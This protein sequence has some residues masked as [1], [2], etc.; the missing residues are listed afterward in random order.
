MSRNEGA[1]ASESVMVHYLAKGYDLVFKQSAFLTVLMFSCSPAAALVESFGKRHRTVCALSFLAILSGVFSALAGSYFQIVPISQSVD[2]M[3][4]VAATIGLNYPNVSNY[5][6]PYIAA[7]GVS[8][9]VCD[10]FLP[11]DN[12]S[13]L[14]GPGQR[15][16]VEPQ[17]I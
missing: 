12:C 10:V 5:Y 1:S 7:A 4:N 3:V 11:N 14:A 8:T 2:A 15:S 6:I 9:V 13:C 16:S 17:L